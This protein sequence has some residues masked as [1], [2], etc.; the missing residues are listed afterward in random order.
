MSI[1]SG[2]CD[3]NILTLNGLAAGDDR[4][5]ARHVNHFAQKLGCVPC[6]H[7]TLEQPW[8]NFGQLHQNDDPATAHIQTS[9][10]RM[11]WS[12]QEECVEFGAER[13]RFVSDTSISAG[14]TAWDR[15]PR[16]ISG[17]TRA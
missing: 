4:K 9:F 8:R 7:L 14:E 13:L 10:S 16:E 3:F 11:R 5:D 6:R 12:F 17:E 2:L 15:L 1:S